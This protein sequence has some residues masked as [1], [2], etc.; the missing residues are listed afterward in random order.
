MDRGHVHVPW[1][2]EPGALQSMGSLAEQQT[3][4]LD[5]VH[6]LTLQMLIPH[7]F[8]HNELGCSLFWPLRG[9]LG[10]LSASVSTIFASLPLCSSR[11][12]LHCVVMGSLVRAQAAKRKRPQN[13]PEECQEPSPQ[14]S[15]TFFEAVSPHPS[16]LVKFQQKPPLS[17]LTGEQGSL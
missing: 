8:S 2:E 1:T 4:T 15:H 7:C 17:T 12:N 16:M 5:F 9:E 13:S 10:K 14:N 6:K 11:P 3:L